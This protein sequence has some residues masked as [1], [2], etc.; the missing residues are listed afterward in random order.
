MRPASVPDRTAVLETARRG[1]TPR[2]AAAR[3]TSS[4][5]AGWACNPAKVEVQVRF[6]ART[7]VTLEP[8]GKAAACKAALQWVRLPPA[9][10]D[11]STAGSDYICTRGKWSE[12]NLRRVV[13]EAAQLNVGT[14]STPFPGVPKGTM[15]RQTLVGHFEKEETDRLP[16]WST[17]L[18]PRWLWVRVPPA[19]FFI[20]SR[21]SSKVEHRNPLIH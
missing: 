11:C 20:E 19:Q 7:L 12:P 13:L 4:G 3:F 6:L 21:R 16:N 15:S 8:D 18:I 1:S 10:L 9:S 14:T 5:C 17:W 2:R